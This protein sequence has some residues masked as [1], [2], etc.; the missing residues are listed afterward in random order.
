MRNVHLICYSIFP[1]I[2]GIYYQQILS[3]V[4]LTLPLLI[5]VSTKNYKNIVLFAIYCVGS[6]CKYID[7]SLSPND[8]AIDDK[9]EAYIASSLFTKTRDRNSKK[10]NGIFLLHRI[11]IGDEWIKVQSCVKI[12]INTSITK[13]S[14]GDTFIFLRSPKHLKNYDNPNAFCYK[15]YLISNGVFYE[16]KVSDG[17]FTFIG[18]K[19]DNYITSFFCNLSDSANNLLLKYIQGDSSVKTILSALILGNKTDLNKDIINAYSR[20]NALHVLAVS[21]LHVGIIFTFVSCLLS[22]FIKNKRHTLLKYGIICVLLIMYSILAGLSPSVVRATIMC[23]LYIMCKLINIDGI[24][25]NIVAISAFIILIFSPDSLYSIG[26]QLSYLAVT[27]IITF[28]HKIYNLAHIKNSILNKIWMCLSVSLSA[29]I[30]ILPTGIYYFHQISTCF[31]ISNLIVI[32]AS[33]I[34]LNGGILVIFL[35]LMPHFEYICHYT[36]ILLSRFIHMINCLIIWISKI[37]YGSFQDIYISKYDLMLYYIFVFLFFVTISSRS[38]KAL[39]TLLILTAQYITYSFVRDLQTFNQKKLIVYD[40]KPYWTIGFIDGINCVLVY[41]E[42][43]I[44]NNFIINTQIMPFLRQH[45]ISN[46]EHH[47]INNK[48]IAFQIDNKKFAIVNDKKLLN[49]LNNSNAFDYILINDHNDT[50][51]LIQNNKDSTN[52]TPI[53]PA[54]TKNLNR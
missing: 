15:Q 22:L 19:T 39:F 47:A 10:I 20:T 50:F 28:Y 6:L 29:Q 44:S 49:E 30:L 53:P 24:P 27:S 34:I 40:V 26:F 13:I 9:C 45:R 42:R 21:G 43:L 4:S 54:Y 11:K 51:T 33:F 38:K 18:N 35:N 36:S 14:Y 17:N 16:H 37:P 32:P 8:I 46:I 7:K 5:C 3:P 12:T 31:L 52:K 23:I 25:Y 48:N 2:A 41:D 1:F